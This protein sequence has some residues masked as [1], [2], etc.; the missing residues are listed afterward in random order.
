M[1]GGDGR[2]RSA[3]R[4]GQLSVGCEGFDSA[5]GSDGG[6]TIRRPNPMPATNP[7]NTPTMTATALAHGFMNCAALSVGAFYY[8]D[9]INWR[10]SS[11]R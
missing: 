7:T 5:G 3:I 8:V 4:S 10:N 6:A 11:K 9:S 2:S 1:G